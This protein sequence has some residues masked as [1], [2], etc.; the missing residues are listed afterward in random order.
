M[1]GDFN[2]KNSGE[3]LKQMEIT[4]NFQAKAGSATYNINWAGS[5]LS[6]QLKKLSGDANLQVKDGVIPVTGDA[7]KMGLGKVLSLFSTQS[8]QRRL[9][10]N[11]SDLGNN[12]YSFN[13]FVTQL[14]F[15]DGNANVRKGEI[16]GPEAKIAFN[17][18]IGLAA[19][20]YNLE[21][22][23]NPY[24]TSTLPLIATLAGG[25]IA[26]VATYAI[27]K[28]ASK[29]IAKITSYHYRLIG[30]WSQPKLVD[31][32]EELKQKQAVKQAKLDA[33]SA[34]PVEDVKIT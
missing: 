11:F 16:D 10:L 27:D 18:R 14:H 33:I 17:G 30:P 5:P 13:T 24:V 31:L 26:G 22:I 21:L 25:P 8:I 29:S 1:Q 20:D 7:A 23:V 34:A 12:G 19:T 28:L 32:D 4:N 2:T 9:K 3:F 6:F 15:Q